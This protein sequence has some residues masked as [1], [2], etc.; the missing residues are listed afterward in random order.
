M[1]SKVNGVFSELWAKVHGGSIRIV[2]GQSRVYVVCGLDE[3]AHNKGAIEPL[4]ARENKSNGVS[5][6]LTK[7]DPQKL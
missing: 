2:S 5:H 3:T 4:Q 7:K 1:T 6:P